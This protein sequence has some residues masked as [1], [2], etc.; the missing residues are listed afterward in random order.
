MDTA[1]GNSTVVFLELEPGT[2]TLTADRDEAVE[3]VGAGDDRPDPVVVDV[4]AGE[5]TSAGWILCRQ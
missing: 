2:Y 1:S 5:L 4:R 3:C